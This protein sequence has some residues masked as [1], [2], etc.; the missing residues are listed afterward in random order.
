MIAEPRRR[1]ILSL[2]WDQEMAAGDIASR[3]DISFGAISQHLGVLREAGFVHVRQDGNHRFYRAAKDR[4]SPFRAILEA[5][6]SDSLHRL[7]TAIEADGD[8]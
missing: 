8:E 7:A 1:Q 6:W 4:L 2:V 5:M 3:F